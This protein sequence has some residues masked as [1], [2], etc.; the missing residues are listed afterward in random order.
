ME[1]HAEPDA[2]A[3]IWA[4]QLD[5]Y[6][7]FLTSDRA[8]TDR[9]IHPDGTMWDSAYEPLIRGLDGLQA[10]RDQRPTGPDAVKVEALEAHD[11]VIT[12]LGDVAITRHLLTVRFEGGAQAPERI[13]NTGV[14]RLTDGTWLNVHNHED[15]LPG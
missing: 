1:N 13:R 12:V 4:A 6:Q 10:V 11:E 7:G 9:H 15:V 2:A 14:W 3:T 8:R 5:M